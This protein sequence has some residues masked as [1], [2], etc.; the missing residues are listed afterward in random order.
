[1]ETRRLSM[2]VENCICLFAKIQFLFLS[3]EI[4]CG[5]MEVRLVL[6]A[7]GR[8]FFRLEIITRTDDRLC[9]YFHC[10]QILIFSF[11]ECEWYYISSYGVLK[12]HVSEWKWLG[13]IN[14]NVSQRCQIEEFCAVTP[15]DS[16]YYSKKVVPRF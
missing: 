8:F 9:L 5:G 4:V 7:I 2:N 12:T 1:M 10:F 13:Q 11:I 14:I 16:L 15:S 3:R 6:R